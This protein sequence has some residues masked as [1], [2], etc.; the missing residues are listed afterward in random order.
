[1][2]HAGP[3]DPDATRMDCALYR[4]LPGRDD[5]DVQHCG[6]Q[7]GD[8]EYSRDGLYL[9]KDGRTLSIQINCDTCKTLHLDHATPEQVTFEGGKA[10]VTLDYLEALGDLE[11][12]QS[13]DWIDSGRKPLEVAWKAETTSTPAKGALQL[14]AGNVYDLLAQ[15]AKGPLVFKRDRGKFK[16]AN[17]SLVSSEGHHAGASVKLRE[18]DLVAFLDRGATKVGTCKYINPT[19]KETKDVPRYRYQ[20][21]MK[22]HDRRTGKQLATKKLGSANPPCEEVISS[23]VRSLGS[24]VDDDTI[25]TWLAG[26]VAKNATELAGELRAA[27]EAGTDVGWV[28]TK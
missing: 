13:K 28:T 23:D 8:S 3:R 12:G 27:E 21:V 1:M 2:E 26:Y 25:E 24:L 14:Q 11:T 20:L 9:S 4:A 18:V 19:T 5:I 16:N 17:I 6:R 7:V 22:V 10:T 15:V